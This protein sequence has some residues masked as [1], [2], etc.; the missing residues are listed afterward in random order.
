MTSG[1]VQV[2]VPCY[3]EAARFDAGAFGRAL[4]RDEELSF[5]LV[6]DGSSDGT[7]SVAF[8]SR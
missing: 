8:V 5:V 4:A 3:N 6:N 7:A 2:V 1:R